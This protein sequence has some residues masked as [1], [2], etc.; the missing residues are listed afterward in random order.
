MPSLGDFF[1][2]SRQGDKGKGV[3]FWVYKFHLEGG[4]VGVAVN[5]R[6]FVALLEGVFWQVVGE[7]DNG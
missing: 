2:R 1:I 6:A 5:D 4:G 3:S 7:A